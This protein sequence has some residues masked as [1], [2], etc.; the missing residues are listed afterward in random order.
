MTPS[1]LYDYFRCA[2]GLSL[3][4]I[5]LGFWVQPKRRPSYLALAFMYLGSGGAFLFSWIS[6]YY[7]L[8]ALADLG[9]L[10]LVTFVLGLS[11][12]DFFVYLLGGEAQRGTRKRLIVL[13]LLWTLLL[14]LLPLADRLLALGP[15]RISIEDQQALGPFR[16]VAYTAVYAW[17]LAMLLFA[18]RIAHNSLA[19]L[20]KHSRAVRL[21]MCNLALAGSIL[22]LTAVGLVLN[23]SWLYRAGHIALQLCLLLWSVFI[24]ARPDVFDQARD[25][26]E[27]SHRERI[28]FTTEE[29][30]AVSRH[31]QAVCRHSGLVTNPATKLSDI[32]KAC[33]LPAY[34]LSAFFNLHCRMTFSE[35]LNRERINL[36]CRLLHDKAELTVLDIAFE[37]GY[38]SKGTFNSQFLRHT[39]MTPSLY[40]ALKKEKCPDS[41]KRDASIKKP[42]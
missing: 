29:A 35:W 24:R 12:L 28:G 1:L 7:V 42:S 11:V 31:L 6:G 2:V 4:V 22:T 23:S 30:S 36:A 41:A 39:G 9:L 27:V 32:A 3:V 37:V 16:S 40:R 34:R 13:G 5:G 38:A 10:L 25:D 19:D 15:V 8:P 17:P 26:I 18:M 20:P 14:W 21:L 33:G